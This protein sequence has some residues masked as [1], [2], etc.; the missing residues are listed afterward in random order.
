MLVDFYSISLNELNESSKKYAEFTHQI[1]KVSIL[2]GKVIRIFFRDLFFELLV[3][4]EVSS[5]VFYVTV[6]HVHF[7]VR[8]IECSLMNRA[9]HNPAV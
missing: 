1:K 4:C 5:F 9:I 6:Y 2:F 3:V 8:R 7:F